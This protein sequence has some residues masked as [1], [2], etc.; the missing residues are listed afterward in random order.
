MAALTLDAAATAAAIALEVAK[1]LEKTE[2]D[3]TS[4]CSGS[5]KPVKGANKAAEKAPVDKAP[6]SPGDAGD[7][8]EGSGGIGANR[9]SIVS[10]SPGDSPGTKL[11]KGMKGEKGKDEEFLF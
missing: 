7:A 8:G 1:E 6:P 5:G 10:S 9:E 3:T 4:A 11:L 2:S